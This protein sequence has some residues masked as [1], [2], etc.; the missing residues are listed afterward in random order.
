[1]TDI[2]SHHKTDEYKDDNRSSG[3][4]IAKNDKRIMNLEKELEF[5]KK[6]LKDDYRM[7][8]KNVKQ[9]PYLNVAIHEYETFFENEKQKNQQKVDA[10]SK[11]LKLTNDEMDKFDILREIKRLNKGK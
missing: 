1:M 5:V 3:V 4:N 2:A 6:Q 11:L 9:N 8:L 10:L 7:M